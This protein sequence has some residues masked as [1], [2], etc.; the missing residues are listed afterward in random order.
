M[1][2]GGH[3]PVLS[4]VKQEGI[5]GVAGAVYSPPGYAF[6]FPYLKYDMW[7]GADASSQ[8]ATQVLDEWATGLAK[9]YAGAGYALK[10]VALYHL[11]DEPGWYYPKAIDDLI[12]NPAAMKRFH[13]YLKAQHLRPSDF[14]AA[15]WQVIRPIGVSQATNSQRRKLFYWTTQFFP[16]D[17]AK[18]FAASTQAMDR[19]F[20]PGIPD[21]VNWNFFSGRSYIPGPVAHNP[22][23][24]SPDAAMGGHDWFEFA[25]LHGSNMLWTEDW[26]GDERAY[27]WSFYAAKLGPAARGAGI[28]WGGYVVPRKSGDAEQGLMQKVL[29]I[30]G[31]GGKAVEYFVFGPE[32]DFPG[33]CYSLHANLI[34][35]RMGTVAH[36]VAAAED[37]LWLGR[38]PQAQVAILQPRSSEVWDPNGIADA[39]N[40]HFNSRT[41]DY[42]AE[43][44]DLYR[45]LQQQNIPADFVA[46][47]ALTPA[48][49]KGYKVLFV[50]EPDFPQEEIPGLMDWVRQ[51]GI[52]VS[53]SGAL[54]ADRYDAPMSTFQQVSG[55]VE[56][57]RKRLMVPDAS[58]LSPVDSLDDGWVVY[59]VRGSIREFKG[60]V[61]AHFKDGT[62]A[63]V[64]N[65]LERGAF[66]HFAFLPGISAYAELSGK[67]SLVPTGILRDSMPG[68]SPSRDGIENIYS[69][70]ALKWIA[71]PVQKAGAQPPVTVDQLD[72]ETPLLLSSQ[73]AAI[74]LLNWRGKNVDRLEVAA[75]VPFK[76][77]TVESVTIGNLPF[78]RK[79]NSISFSM[80][81]AGADI[82]MLKK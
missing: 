55:I 62:P 7:K 45:G 82:V 27:D 10:N 3:S 23:K 51:G 21:P 71:Y 38:K 12:A 67:S 22:A 64:Q 26:F 44:Y 72:V 80:P 37:L 20:Y 2:L 61:L 58:L 4:V 19:A 66:I 73:G 50:T 65:R 35:P 42:M 11:A 54:A 13:D 33:N 68:T 39:T 49:L 53:V 31:N 17:S 43:T 34:L 16:W 76:V 41:T 60:A 28:S 81:L 36:M 48:D 78:S 14:G 6:E 24:T 69:A 59:G 75:R 25:K 32:Y 46:E 52:L 79:G 74:T 9:P 57:P 1:L 40:T 47:D 63:I 30:F 56:M 5:S 70:T 77:R 15:S 29:S 18:H 8:S